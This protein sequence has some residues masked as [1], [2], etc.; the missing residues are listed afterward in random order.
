MDPDALNYNPNASIPTTNCIY[1]PTRELHAGCM[2]TEAINIQLTAN[3][4]CPTCCVY[5]ACLDP[6][7]INYNPS[8][9]KAC[10]DC[11]QYFSNRLP[12][13]LKTAAKRDLSFFAPVAPTHTSA[14][15][16]MPAIQNQW[17][18]K[19]YFQ[20]KRISVVALAIMFG[21]LLT[22]W[23]YRRAWIES[24]EKR[25]YLPTWP[26]RHQVS[27][28]SIGHTRL[29]KPVINS[30]KP[31]IEKETTTSMV[32][33]SNY[34]EGPHTYLLLIDHHGQQ[35]H[36]S[37]FYNQVAQQFKQA[38][39]SIQHYFFTDRPLI[40]W[41]DKHRAGIPLETLLDQFEE[42]QVI[43]FS[44]GAN[45]VDPFRQELEYWADRF[46]FWKNRVW[47]TPIPLESWGN[48]EFLLAQQFKIIPPSN[49]GFEAILKPAQDFEFKREWIN[50]LRPHAISPL[51]PIDANNATEV[52]FKHFPEKI[53]KWIAACCIYSELHP[54]LTLEIGHQVLGEDFINNSDWLLILQLPWFEH[55][56]IPDKIRQALI[57][58]LSPSEQATIHQLIHKYLEGTTPVIDSSYAKGIHEI[59]TTSHQL[60]KKPQHKRTQDRW[61]PKLHFLQFLGLPIDRTN[62]D[63]I[64]KRTAYQ[65]ILSKSLK[66]DRS[67]TNL[68]YYAL[69]AF[70][71]ALAAMLWR[72]PMQGKLDMLDGNLYH[73]ANPKDSLDF[74]TNKAW[75]AVQK[76]RLNDV[77]AITR[78][79]QSNPY[80]QG[81]IQPYQDSIFSR[82]IQ[83]AQYQRAIDA[84][85]KKHF[86]NALQWLNQPVF[87]HFN[88]NN[89]ILTVHD[90]WHL[91]GLTYWQLG[92]LDSARQLMNKIENNAPD[93]WQQQRPHLKHALTYEFVDSIAYGHIR[94]RQNRQYQFLDQ[95]GQLLPQKF[96]FAY[97]FQTTENLDAALT[98][99]DTVALVYHRRQ[100]QFVGPKGDFIPNTTFK[101]LIPVQCGNSQWGYTNS[102]DAPIIAC[103]FEKAWPFQADQ[104]LAKVALEGKIGYIKRNGAYG[105]LP[106]Y[107]EGDN[108]VGN[109]ANVRLND[110]WGYIDATGNVVIPFRFD[111]AEPFTN[112]TAQVEIGNTRFKI[113][114]YGRCLSGNNCP[115]ASF[116]IRIVER[117]SQRPV[118]NATISHPIYGKLTTSEVGIIKLQL[119]E[120]LLPRQATFSVEAAGFVTE[121]IA[122][123]LA[124]GQSI[125]TIYLDRVQ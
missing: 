37:W 50:S 60:L 32:P 118:S 125:P 53:R 1:A 35:D 95:H 65:P 34:S 74:K 117:I 25:T 31:F 55:G 102:K 100:F 84:Y 48:R 86:P 103:R 20:R 15:P 119:L 89:Q 78:N 36:R 94:I 67:L 44:E 96:D 56:F 33:F 77:G 124:A 97:P 71:I 66:P 91:L 41:N 57:P 99:E 2:D 72:A 83:I 92:Q 79:V 29:I 113:D 61:F 82:T 42:A 28:K 58:I 116:T 87:N 21:L 52:V 47:M 120:H 7:A 109:R 6:T 63:M 19:I 80:F 54:L 98:R 39:V 51:P 46:K 38:G 11:C 111:S 93:Y 17:Y 101:R 49:W 112:G 104:E 4:S 24:L 108:F 14:P 81:N 110:Q 18:W 5:E 10:T 69:F 30:F 105:V 64:T 107:D 59:E 123:T 90:Y 85:H 122:L 88:A 3:V 26:Y 12:N 9:S 114:E 73:I 121:E 27:V 70:I 16:I 40:F 43:I 8:A 106:I 76:D 115:V 68:R 62:L 45:W 13:G 23:L 22:L 75:F